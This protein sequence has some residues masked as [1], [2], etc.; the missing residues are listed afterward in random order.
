MSR[1]D[2]TRDALYQRTEKILELTTSQK[3]LDELKAVLNTAPEHQ[4][5]EAAK[6]FA[7]DNLLA[8][9][10]AISPDVRISSRIFDEPTGRVRVLGTVASPSIM[11]NNSLP[12]DTLRNLTPEQIEEMIDRKALFDK[13]V[14]DGW[15]VCV[16]V[17][18]GGCV[19]VG[20]GS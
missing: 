2:Y 14:E 13:A 19:G 16:C 9:G 6:R 5:D 8:E 4:L 7:P 10:I 17:G 18:A 11:I 20:G 12:L 1:E 15:S 3:F